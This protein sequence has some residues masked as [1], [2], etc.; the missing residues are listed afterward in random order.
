VTSTGEPD[1]AQLPAP[2]KA[3]AGTLRAGLMDQAP[4]AFNADHFPVLNG[5]KFMLKF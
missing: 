2:A 5:L 3:H 4:A 1:S